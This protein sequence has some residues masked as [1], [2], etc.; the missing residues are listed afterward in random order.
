MTLTVVVG[1]QWGDEGKG[2]LTDL[3]ASDADIVARFGGGDNAGHTVRVGSD[4]FQLHATPSGIVHNKVLCIIGN[5]VVLNPQILL[6]ELDGL[7]A[8]GVDVSPERLR[9]SSAAHL[10]TPAHIALDRAMELRRGSASIGTTLRGIG[11]A[12]ADKASRDGLRA[13]LLCRPDLLEP[14]MHEHVSAKNE[15]LTAVYG[16]Q[17][18]NANEIAADFLAFAERLAPYVDETTTLVDSAL[19]QGKLVLAEGAQGTMLDLDHGSYPF[20]T[21]SHPTVPGALSGLGVGATFLGRAIGVAKAFSTRVGEGPFPTE[22][23]G[24]IASRLRGTGRQPWDEFG[25]TTGRPR[26]VGWLDLVPLR[27]AARV[28]GLTELAITKLDILSGLKELK[29]CTSYRVDGR[30]FDSIPSSL[31]SG[32]AIEPEYTSMPGW[33]QEVRDVRHYGLLPEEAREYLSFIEEQ[34]RLPIRLVSVGPARD[35]II[36]LD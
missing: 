17:S 34:L 19:R 9:I 5:G 12:Y 33:Q 32:S 7:A 30:R 11:P 18:L 6:S 24:G 15:L 8:R 3:L 1:A 21:S 36:R 13:E 20:V 23:S 10:V 2:R 35:E 28:N 31:K 27:L 14:A 22:L 16:A 25:T 4:T 26:R 29:I